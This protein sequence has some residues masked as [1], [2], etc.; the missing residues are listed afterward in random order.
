MILRL[1]T[2]TILSSLARIVDQS[3]SGRHLSKNG[4][5]R[6]LADT[7]SLRQ[8][9]VE[10]VVR[11]NEIVRKRCEKPIVKAYSE[12]PKAKPNQ[13]LNLT[14]KAMRFYVKVCGGL[15]VRWPAG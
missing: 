1:S 2:T 9:V 7:F 15:K 13:S 8:F 3:R 4:G 11:R 14:G 5:T 10:R 6:K 12:N